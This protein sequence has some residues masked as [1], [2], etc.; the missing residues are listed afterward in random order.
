MLKR[1]QAYEALKAFRSADDWLARH[2]GAIA[3]LPEPL[4]EIA[5]ALLDRNANGQVDWQNGD[6][7]RQT[8]NRLAEIEER[9]RAQIFGVLFSRIAEYVEISWTLQSRLPYQ[10]NYGKPFR[11]P[12]AVESQQQINWLQALLRSV[13]EYEQ[14]ISWYAVWAVHIWQQDVLG[15]LLAGAIESGGDIG[16]DIFNTL[17]TCARGEHEIGAMGKHVVRALLIASRPEG[18]TFIENLLIAAQRQEG[19]R[20]SILETID[21]SHPEAFRRMV[22]LILERDLLRFSATIRAVDKW[23]GLGW[24]VSHKK[25]AERSLQVI[26]SCLEDTNALESYLHGEDPQEAYL[27]LWAIAFDNALEAI[28]PATELLQHQQ[29]E[30]RFVAAFLLSQLQLD[31]AKQVLV[32]A[33][34][35]PDMRVAAQAFYSISYDTSLANTDLF[36]RIEALLQQVPANTKQL[37]PIVWEWMALHLYR[38]QI[39]NSL[40]NL[41]GDRSPRILVPYLAEMGVWQRIQVIKL[42]ADRQPWDREVEEIIFAAASDRSSHCRSEIFKLL[43]EYSLTS[44]FVLRFE[45][46]LTRKG[47]D[48][49]RDVLNLLLRQADEATLSSAERLLGNS[50]AAQRASGLELLDEMVRAK[51]SPQSCYELVDAYR[52]RKGKR[53]AAEDELL[54]KFN[55]PSQQETPTSENGFGLFD[56]AQ[57]PPAI[58]PEFPD[59]EVIL[60]TD[61]A[62][63]ILRS[64][65]D[66]I[67]EHRATP[68]RQRNWDGTEG[69]EQLLGNANWLG[70]PWQYGDMNNLDALPLA[71]VWQTWW[72]ERP[73]ELRDPD[74]ME[75][76]RATVAIGNFGATDFFQDSSFCRSYDFYDFGDRTPAWVKVCKQRLVTQAG[77]LNYPMLVRSLIGW[78][79]FLYPPSDIV[80]FALDASQ[81]SLAII[82][83]IVLQQIAKPSPSNDLPGDADIESELDMNLNLTN[84]FVQMGIPSEV[85]GAMGDLEAM[86]PTEAYESIMMNLQRGIESQADTFDWR[87][88]GQLTAWLALTCQYYS[89]NSNTWTQLQVQRLWN[90]LRWVDE[91]TGTVPLWLPME[92]G[93]FQILSVHDRTDRGF[94][95]RCRP[96]LA[97]LLRGFGAGIA[98][99]TDI[100]D[101]LIGMQYAYNYPELRALTQRN[102]DR[103]EN[104]YVRATEPNYQYLM[105]LVDRCRD[106]IL[107]IEYARGD[108]PTPAT[109]AAMS[110]Q[111]VIG[112]PPVIKLLQNLGKEQLARGWS[113]DR[114]SKASVFSHLLRVSFPAATDTP[115]DFAQQVQAAGISEQRLIELALFAPQWSRYVERTLKWRAFAEAVWWFHAHTKDSHW[116][117]EQSIRE[118][119]T[120]QVAEHTPLTSQDLLDGAVDVAWFWRAYS[121]MRP[122]Q[123][124]AIHEA[125]K[126]AAGGQGHQRARLFADAMLGK[127]AKADSIKRIQSKRHQDS[128]RALGLIPLA[129][130]K[131]READLLERYEVVQEFLRT[132]KQFGSQRQASEKLATRIALENLSR[133]AGYADPQRLEWAMEAKAIADL[134]QGPVVITDGEVSISLSL[135]ESGTA[136]LGVTKKGKSQKTIPAALKKKPEIVALQERKQKLSQQSSRMRIS[137]EQAMCRGDRFTVAEL[138]QLLAHPILRPMLQ[139]L[140]FIGEVVIGYP[141]PDG[142]GLQNYD[143][144]ISAIDD[145]ITVQIAHPTDLVKTGVWHLWQPECFDRERS[146]PFKQVFRELYIPIATEQTEHKGSRRYAGHQ[147]NPRQAMA[148]FGQRGWLTGS[149]YDYDS[150]IHRVFYDEDIAVYIGVD[151]GW[152]TPAEVEGLTIDEVSFSHRSRGETLPL[153]AVPPRVF[154]EVMRDLD[155]VVSVAHQGGVDPEASASTVEMRSALIRETNRLLK[156]SNVSLQNS[157][158]LIEGELGSYSVHLGSG[159]VHRQ[160]GG[161]L[162]IIPVHSQHRGRIFLPFADDDPKTAEIVSKILLLA[163]DREIQDPTIL[164]QIL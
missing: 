64:L 39:A 5:W 59:R 79:M 150:D 108:L 96:S 27:A 74:G 95:R 61:A 17:L 117:V 68:I 149:S 1:E 10:G 42:L 127:I 63:N 21:E 35:D 88:N 58:P 18:W 161:S 116:E 158:A 152:S 20:Q 110:L 106:R 112:I 49:R 37:K 67:H 76:L 160:P 45:E 144:R 52:T 43:K 123:W 155:L 60:V 38:E 48:L 100:L 54:Q 159:V 146:Q 104:H 29:V 126:F 137:L 141:I 11:V 139:N 114:A 113:Y 107:E 129:K 135:D 51:R 145:E 30:M 125:A 81:Y 140:I 6:R 46:L 163:K 82:R 102:R 50:N 66:L 8:A 119:W 56:P 19:L 109:A 134:A 28:A 122:H 101:C 130:G 148:L 44:E 97:H 162:C 77:K 53:T 23:F 164:Q 57:R 132:S 24:D 133:T 71:S 154:S 111:S 70:S 34:T 31:P 99:E 84:I 138:R 151:R 7:I 22:R 69:E 147:V 80:N 9:D 4:R 94:I 157:Y 72:E 25:I 124:E 103:T 120:A 90:L 14:E 142:S 12:L 62:K 91:P 33:L 118:G 36:E 78:L 87:E 26:S 41:L 47:S 136:H 3:Q 16:E 32:P 143:G 156:L 131:K 75:L 115:E 65:D 153:D 128:V 105:E 86:L 15:I 89:M 93:S 121:A 55:E 73:A 83:E 2:Q 40:V 92:H 13:Q 85:F 98:T